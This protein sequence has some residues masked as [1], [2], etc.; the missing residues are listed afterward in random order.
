MVGYVFSW[1]WSSCHWWRLMGDI[2]NRV[3]SKSSS[4][5]VQSISWMT[6]VAELWIT[7]AQHPKLLTQSQITSGLEG[8]IF[9]ALP[10]GEPSQGLQEKSRSTTSKGSIERVCQ[11]AKLI[12]SVFT[13]RLNI[14]KHQL[15]HCL[16]T[17]K[18]D[19][20]P[21]VQVVRQEQ[22]TW[23]ILLF[24][25]SPGYTYALQWFHWCI[26]HVLLWQR[27]HKVLTAAK[28]FQRALISASGG[29]RL[30]KGRP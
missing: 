15:L 16:F 4:N 13:Q 18:L 17:E 10:F 21:S 29:I 5:C 24:K 20:L 14:V 12:S 2:G 25:A 11:N 23:I 27:Q 7:V 19:C 1:F 8:F 22:E 26:C 6:K 28:V 9:S 3:I 30:V